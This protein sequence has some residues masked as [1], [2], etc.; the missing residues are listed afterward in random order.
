VQGAAL[1]AQQQRGFAEAAVAP[2]TTVWDDLSDL[3]TS[4]E[5]K[6]EL[7]TL[8]STYVDIAQKLNSM[9][10]VSAAG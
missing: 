7:A 1:A 8:R 3:V 5:G 4:D 6:R 2:T 9:A 10:K